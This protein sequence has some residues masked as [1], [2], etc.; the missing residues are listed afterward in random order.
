M[1]TNTKQFSITGICKNDIIDNFAET[2]RADQVKAKVDKMTGQDMIRL[3]S[4]LE[5]AYVDQLLWDSLT[6]IFE[7]HFLKQEV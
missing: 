2:R 6:A 3:A 4:M 5:D 1:I 7:E